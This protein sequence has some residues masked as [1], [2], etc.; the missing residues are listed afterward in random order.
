[1]E[2][3]NISQPL[4]KLTLDSF[5]SVLMIDLW[6]KFG[7]GEG[8]PNR[9]F[10]YGL[11]LLCFIDVSFATIE[12]SFSLVLE[13]NTSKDFLTFF[14]WMYSHETY[15]TMRTPETLIEKFVYVTHLYMTL[16]TLQ[17]YNAIHEYTAGEK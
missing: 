8:N 12:Y 4:R 10:I 16:Q 14:T 15:W 5:T 7:R 3:W 17:Y 9:W 11:S 6:Q 2:W 13:S 1:M